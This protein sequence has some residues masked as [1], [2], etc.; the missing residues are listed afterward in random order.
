MVCARRSPRTGDK[1]NRSNISV[2][3]WHAD[4]YP[5]LI[6]Q[7]TPQRVAEH[8]AHRQPTAG[9]QAPTRLVVLSDDEN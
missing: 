2:M 8:F 9:F 4:L 1:G 5:V 3:A 6:R 7:L